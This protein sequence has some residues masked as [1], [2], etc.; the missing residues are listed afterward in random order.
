MK[1][2]TTMEPRK[3]R[4]LMIAAVAKIIRKGDDWLV[5]SQSGNG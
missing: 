4:G 1:D 5:P 3:Q 2:N